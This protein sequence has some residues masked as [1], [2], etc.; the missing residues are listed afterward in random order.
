MFCDKCY[1]VDAPALA[2]ENHSDNGQEKAQPHRL[3]IFHIYN[4]LCYFQVLEQLLCRVH[5]K[6]VFGCRCHT[7]VRAKTLQIR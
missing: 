3:F 5:R 1:R 6:F 2:N 4:I 7:S